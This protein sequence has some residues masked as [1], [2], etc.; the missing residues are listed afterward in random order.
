MK[1]TSFGQLDILLRDGDE[2]LIEHLRFESKGR[3]HSHERYESFFVIS[4][5]GRVVSGESIYDVDE[6]SLVTIPPRTDH[7]MEPAENVVLEGFLW[8]HDKPLD[9][10][11]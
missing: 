5:R 3:G 10:K 9:I 7:W 1:A 2:P 6:G 4:G 11:G 8:Y